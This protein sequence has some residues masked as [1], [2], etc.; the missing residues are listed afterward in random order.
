MKGF[1]LVVLFSAILPA[2]ILA[3]DSP[4]FRGNAQ[5]SGVYSAG[6]VSTF[7]S[8]KWKFHTA[9]RVISSP[10][11]VGGVAY[12]GST[13]C[14]LYAIDMQA[15]AQKWKFE[16]KGWVVST[17]AVASGI[18]Y[19]LSYDGN[20]YAVDT[21]AGQLKWKF[22]T[23][24]ERRYAGTHLHYLQPVTERMPDPWDVFLS[25][26]AVWNGAVYFGSSDGNVYALDAW[27]GSLK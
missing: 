5:H 19:F 4:M 17:P 20:F 9:G 24:G 25:S 27:S 13:D 10:A 22:A 18:V 15:G 7:N 1:C 8:V 11:V 21:T 2:F 26:P 3:Q 12:V 16:T 23:G 14:N 6:G